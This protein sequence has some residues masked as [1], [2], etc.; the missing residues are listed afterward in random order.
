MLH[1]LFPRDLAGISRVGLHSGAAYFTWPLNLLTWSIMIWRPGL[2]GIHMRTKWMRT[3]AVSHL[4][5]G[6]APA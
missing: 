2:L 4:W 6:H 1:S 3:E 5:L